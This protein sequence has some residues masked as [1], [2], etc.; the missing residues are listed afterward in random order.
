M[1]SSKELSSCLE[2]VAGYGGQVFL[3]TGEVC[4]MCNVDIQCTIG[5]VQVA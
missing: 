5:G 3:L 2:N 1:L 4:S